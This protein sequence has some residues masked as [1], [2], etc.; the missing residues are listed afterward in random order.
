MSARLH[1]VL[2][3]Y[4]AF[5]MATFLGAFLLFQLQ[6]LIGKF[7]LPWFGGATAVWTVCL[8][9]FQV[10][11]LAGYAYA[12]GLSRLPQRWQTLVHLGVTGTGLLFMP[13]APNRPLPGGEPTW[14]ILALLLAS[15]GLP[16]FALAATSPLLQVWFYRTLPERSPYRLY[17]LSNAGSLL[18]LIS[19]PFVFEPLFSRQTLSQLWSWGFG[20]FCLVLMACAVRT[21][22]HPAPGQRLAMRPLWVLL[23]AAGSVMLLATT[24]KICQ[25][26]AVVPFLWI[27]P[28]ALYLLS[29][30]V[31]FN[32]SR[33]YQRPIFLSALV[34]LSVAV[35][36]M[37]F[38][39][40]H[41]PLL[42]QIAVY[43][44]WLFVCCMVCH[45]EVFRLRPHPSGLTGFYLS[46]AAGGALGG[47]FV[48]L[49]A[50]VL[51]NNY[52][53]LHLGM[54]LAPALL[55]FVLKAE[56]RAHAWK[57]AAALTVL[58]AWA[59]GEHIAR[60]HKDVVAQNRNFY[61]VLRVLEYSRQV[62]NAHLRRMNSGDITHG[63]QYVHRDLAMLPTSYYAEP[64]GV[65]QALK[66]ISPGQRRVGIVG[67]GIGT[68]AA[69]GHAGDTFRFYE[70]NPASLAFAREH[71]SYLGRATSLVEVVLGDARVS[72]ERE[73]PQSY[74]LLALDAFS[75]D[76]VPVH[77]L[78]REAFT[79][80][81]RHLKR[82]GTI[83]VH[84]TNRHLD[85]VPVVENI[86]QH[87]GLAATYVA[88]EPKGIAWHY[89][90]YWMLLKRIT[91]APPPRPDRVR[92]W[93]DD[94][95]S[96]LP[97]LKYERR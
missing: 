30:I 31:A 18:A 50:P 5:G 38:M 94:Y 16:Y 61:G 73:P 46:I 26:V 71:F 63:E 80:Y 43:C 22:D 32:D 72:L 74:D 85:L 24:N 79:A 1:C 77:L 27:A 75:G 19:F 48:G 41:P 65:G 47:I 67:L 33:W 42:L 12:H 37:L 87:H 14:Q 81:Q 11:L 45:G 4:L 35:C 10:A 6:P 62:P 13:I 69:Y 91:N 20:A 88:Y 17:A 86:A 3:M 39:A 84:V 52:F 60:L 34:L 8:L 59:L 92:L 56:G 93:T 49:V 2:G 66:A 57:T 82:D 54:L 15:V 89:A 78:T 7:I 23:P 76:A 97:L 40:P 95:A 9:F 36:L 55:V 68:L 25:D 70:I 44:A 64:S 58:L 83:A 96:L 28:L 53:E 90:S 21:R 51:F 29:F